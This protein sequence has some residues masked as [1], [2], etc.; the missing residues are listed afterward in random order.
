MYNLGASVAL[1]FPKDVV[2]AIANS[3]V[4]DEV[5]IVQINVSIG[6]FVSAPMGIW[7]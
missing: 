1:V 4:D 2:G 6:R 5:M 7:A 3:E